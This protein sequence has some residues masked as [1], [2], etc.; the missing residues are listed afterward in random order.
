ME[1]CFEHKI[2]VVHS[3]R[4]I[5]SLASYAIPVGDNQA[6]RCFF[7]PRVSDVPILA[8]RLHYL[9][10]SPCCTGN[11]AH[12]FNEDILLADQDGHTVLFSLQSLTIVYDFGRILQSQSVCN[13][14]ALTL[15]FSNSARCVKAMRAKSSTLDS[16]VRLHYWCASFDSSSTE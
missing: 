4:S 3:R 8:G 6:R 7:E 12:V 10:P 11:A 9:F 13:T 14:Q 5:F 16:R 2:L 1:V 15:P